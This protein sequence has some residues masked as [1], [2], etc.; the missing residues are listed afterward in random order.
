MLINGAIKLLGGRDDK[1]SPNSIPAFINGNDWILMG[2]FS[3]V[4][5][6]FFEAINLRLGSWKYAGIPSELFIRWPG[7]FIAFATVLPAIFST[8]GF[9]AVIA[10]SPWRPWQSHSLR[11][12]PPYSDIRGR[13]DTTWKFTSHILEIC[14][15]VGIAMIILPLTWPRIFYPL[16]WGGL[17]LF[18]EP[19]NYRHGYPSL[20]KD[21]EQ[22]NFNR[23]LCL[24][25]SGL[26]CGFLWETFNYWAGAKWMY[27]LPRIT[28]P[29]IF[30]M[31]LLGYSGFPAFA[32]EC[33]TA[34]S[35]FTAKWK[36]INLQSKYTL[37][38]AGVIFS[39]VMLHAIDKY[40][41]I[42]YKSLLP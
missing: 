10:R 23:I 20:F 2:F 37:A 15:I 25:V 24:A 42:S 29:K 19:I 8:A 33:F 34:W 38:L 13:N 14:Q 36:E 31:P 3:F 27:V 5:W 39:L 26:I 41:V 1:P 6:L 32:L 28:G 35:L 21:V 9:V 16:V 30:E 17:F 7:T 18:L 40:T 22:S 12:F 4:F 11:L